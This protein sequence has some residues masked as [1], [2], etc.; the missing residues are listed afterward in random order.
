M[1][2]FLAALG[3]MVVLF[4]SFITGKALYEVTH[5]PVPP[6]NPVPLALAT[7]SDIQRLELEMHRYMLRIDTALAGAKI[8]TIYK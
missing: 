2:N 6:P 7:A 1:N 5:P 8:I 4:G 3:V